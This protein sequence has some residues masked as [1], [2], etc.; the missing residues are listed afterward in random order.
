MF[1]NALS[2]LYSYMVS[3]FSE[4]FCTDRSFLKCD[5]FSY[6]WKPFSYL[7]NSC[8]FKLKRFFSKC[9]NCQNG[10]SLWEFQQIGG[11]EQSSKNSWLDCQCCLWSYYFIFRMHEKDTATDIKFDITMQM[12][13]EHVLA[14]K[15][16]KI[17]IAKA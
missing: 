17:P 14:Q 12:T 16:T 6:C 4:I 9:D 13:L 1:T 8:D 7:T 5:L 3:L 15:S 2:R 10:L 11:I